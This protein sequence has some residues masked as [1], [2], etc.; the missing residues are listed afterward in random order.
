MGNAKNAGKTTVLNAL[1]AVS[2]GKRSAV[3]S[4]GLDGEDLDTVSRLPK[5]R[6]FLPVGS[7]V[8]SAEGCLHQSDASFHILRGTG[9]RTGLGEVLIA[10]VTRAGNCLVGGP[11]S[12][13]AVAATAEMLRQ[14]GAEKIFIDGAFSRA[15]HTVAGEAVV[16]VAG[17]H[18]S[19]DMTSVVR[20]AD[21]ALKRLALPPAGEQFSHLLAEDRPGWL[22]EQHA[23]HPI[24]VRSVPGCADA[25]LDQVPREAR[26]LFLPGA[27]GP[28]F[29]RRFVMRRES[30]RCG[31]ILSGPSA[32]VA[33]GTELA[34][35]L[36]LDRDILVLRPLRVAFV[37]VNPFSPAG[38]RFDSAA[39]MKAL[40]GITPLPLINVLED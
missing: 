12:S 21:C 18:F 26:F 27:L 36:R 25:V 33:G 28:H 19:R 8:A 30:H 15:S 38:Y 13:S 24:S 14:A 39:F 31:L 32:L 40:E 11:S 7:L 20:D 10:R 4:I 9:V 3:T 29:A 22:D 23:F 17:A 37:A 6:V 1:V 5:P 16:F 2:Q 35:L 34:H